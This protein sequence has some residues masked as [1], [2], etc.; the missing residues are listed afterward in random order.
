M[1]KSI[2]K[3]VEYV[4][5]PDGNCQECECELAYDRWNVYC[6]AFNRAKIAVEGKQVQCLACVEFLIR[7]RARSNA[8]VA[9]MS[10]TIR[11]R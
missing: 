2:I 9:S 11:D 5:E 6:L 3:T 4:I 7:E 1:E 10:A 8:V